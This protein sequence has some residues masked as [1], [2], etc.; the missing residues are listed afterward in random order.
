MM[1]AVCS[2]TQEE[3]DLTVAGTGGVAERLRFADGWLPS[4]LRFVPAAAGAPDVGVG[5]L[6]RPED[7]RNSL[8]PHG[9]AS[10]LE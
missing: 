9:N 2:R 5:D 6:L 10:L 7:K 3:P 4:A 8:F 1:L